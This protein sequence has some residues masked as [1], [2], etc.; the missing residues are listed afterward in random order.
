VHPNAAGYSRVVEALA[1]ALKR[2][3]AV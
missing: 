2:G 3:G 1:Q